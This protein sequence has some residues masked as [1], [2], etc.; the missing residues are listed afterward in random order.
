MT[1][2]VTHKRAR[3]DYEILDTFEAGI[4]LLGF[5]VK[6]LKNKHGSL[7]GA[8]ITVR[9]N[10]AF[11]IGMRIPPY[12]QA[13][14][15]KDYDENRLRKLLLSKKEIA[16]LGEKEGQRGLTIVPISVYNKERKVKLEIAVVRGKKK[17]DKRQTL[18][19]RDTDRDIR[20]TLKNQ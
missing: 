3:F 13:N 8:H 14:T 4:Q 10:E 20:R 12:Q 1:R 5:E 7:E 15:P 18:K 16:K 17:T 6:S 9:G 2:L 11:I 19:K